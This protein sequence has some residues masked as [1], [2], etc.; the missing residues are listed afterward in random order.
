MAKV[1]AAHRSGNPF[2]PLLGVHPGKWFDHFGPAAAPPF[3]DIL[4]AHLAALLHGLLAEGVEVGGDPVGL[5]SAAPVS[6]RPGQFGGVGQVADGV[7]DRPTLGR[8]R[9]LPILGT[10]LL[11][12]LIEKLLFGDEVRQELSHNRMVVASRNSKFGP[13]SQS[14]ARRGRL[15]GSFGLFLLK[16]VGG[17]DGFGG[18]DHERIEPIDQLAQP[19]V[20]AAIEMEDK[21]STVRLVAVVLVSAADG[22]PVSIDPEARSRRIPRSTRPVCGSSGPVWIRKTSRPST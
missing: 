22:S 16:G 8:S 17:L 7:P 13:I 11:E 14:R 3:D 19:A 18:R 15:P 9:L 10:D 1:R 20:A 4:I 12:E 21:R 2:D 6:G 5:D